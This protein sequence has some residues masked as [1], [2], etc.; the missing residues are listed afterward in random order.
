MIGA[1]LIEVAQKPTPF[2]SALRV[3]I[4]MVSALAMP[5]GCVPLSQAQVTR[6]EVTG[7][8]G[9]L[10]A[11]AI[12]TEH[13]HHTAI[14]QAVIL[15][16]G[17]QVTFAVDLGQIN[18]RV[19]GRL[20]IDEALANRQR[21]SFNAPGRGERF[22]HGVDCSGWRLG[23]IVMSRPEFAQAARH[24]LTADLF[25][26]DAI[27]PVSVPA[28]LFQDALAQANTAGIL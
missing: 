20:R 18:D 6:G 11:Q 28:H 13:P 1:D 3:L 26:P 17:E 9:A 16:Q 24:G 10:S 22:C 4:V 19:H 5:V 23:E 21:L 25:G 14:A 15:Q 7:I 12:V 2:G 27:L 8:T